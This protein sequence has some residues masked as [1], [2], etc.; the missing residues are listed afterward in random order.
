VAAGTR[1]LGA[2]LLTMNVR[3]FPMIDGLRPAY[4]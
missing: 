3:H 2:E 1:L 4:A